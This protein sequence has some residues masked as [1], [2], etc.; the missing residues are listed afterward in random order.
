MTPAEVKKLKSTFFDQFL[1]TEDRALWDRFKATP[2]RDLE[3]LAAIHAEAIALAKIETT[4]NS[5]LD[6]EK[7]TGM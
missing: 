2:V 1:A 6:T 5:V 7:I 3:A 4:L